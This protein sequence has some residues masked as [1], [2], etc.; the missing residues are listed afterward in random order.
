[1]V[2][3]IKA[4]IKTVVAI[5]NKS[6]LLSWE[7]AKMETEIAPGGDLADAMKNMQNDPG[8]KLFLKKYFLILKIIFRTHGR[9][10]RGPGRAGRR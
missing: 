9:L 4:K 10:R 1:M 3:Q 7:Q 8:E 5:P 6:P 2:K